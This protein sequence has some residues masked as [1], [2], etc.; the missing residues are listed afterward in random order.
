ML[1]NKIVKGLLGVSAVAVLFAAFAV[2]AQS[3]G[4]QGSQQTGPGTSQTGGQTSSG[5]ATTASLSR[6]DRKV[7]V[8]LAMSNMA[9]IEAGPHRPDQKPERASQE[10]R[11]ANDR[12]PHRALNDVKQLAQAR[13]VTPPT[14]LDRKHKA[15]NARMAALSGEAYDRAYLS[16]AG[17]ADHKKRMTN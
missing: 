17:V 6:A 14:E 16:Q 10:L 3:T 1:K 13:G 7:V 15:K 9:E 11:P 5:T 4:A 12:R 8:E 2:H